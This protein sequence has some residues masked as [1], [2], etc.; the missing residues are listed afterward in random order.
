MCSATSALLKHCSS[1]H[2]EHH[3]QALLKQCPTNVTDV[4]TNNFGLLEHSGHLSNVRRGAE[5]FHPLEVQTAA[6]AALRAGLIG[7]IHG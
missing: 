6:T 4:L 1:I 5:R 3:A 2:A 7:A